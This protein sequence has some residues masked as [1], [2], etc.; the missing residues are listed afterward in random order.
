MEIV[1]GIP[2][3]PGFGIGSVHIVNQEEYLIREINLLSNEKAEHE[4]GLFEAALKRTRSDLASF[5]KTL[6]RRLGSEESSIF[7][8][9][10]HIL[11]DASLIEKTLHL[12]RKEHK[13]A[14][15]AF[16]KTAEEIIRAM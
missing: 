12:I 2:V 7:D 9:H 3:A 15:F 8:A 5:K 16:K 11:S 13:N 6:A 14:A 10:L 4:V 1:K